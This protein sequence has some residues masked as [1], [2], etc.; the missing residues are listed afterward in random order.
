MEKENLRTEV[1]EPQTNEG[2]A[3]NGTAFQDTI[4]VADATLETLNKSSAKAVDL[5]NPS[6]I[7]KGLE[8]LGIIMPFYIAIVDPSDNCTVSSSFFEDLTSLEE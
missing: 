1:T 3:A 7:V 8:A 4:K 2:I 5:K 6:N